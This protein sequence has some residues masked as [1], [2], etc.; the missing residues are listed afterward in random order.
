MIC[1]SGMSFIRDALVLPCMGCLILQ[2]QR[3]SRRLLLLLII[4]V[5]SSKIVYGQ[6]TDAHEYEVK[7]AFLY[8]FAR[9]FKW[10]ER[11]SPGAGNAF[12]IGIVGTDPF[13]GIL[14]QAM[15]GKT[16][17]GKSVIVRRY[18]N[19]SEATTCDMLFIGASETNSL[20]KILAL[21]NNAPI[22]TVGDMPQFAQRGGMINLVIHDNR[23][24][25]EVNVEATERA[26]L[27]PSS[28]LLR[29]A[30]IVPDSTVDH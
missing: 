4:A 20:P 1:S 26:R 17:Q 30:K 22:L 2:L 28:Q 13:G 14:D 11:P 16:L 3:W 6:S 27:T 9:Y 5:A 7:A 23:V 12:V 10:P 21:L 15:Q 24:Q 25:F 8:N 18:A 19:P 29:L